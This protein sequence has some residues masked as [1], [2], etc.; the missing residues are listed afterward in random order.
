MTARL[1]HADDY[2]LIIVLTWTMCNIP[3]AR[4]FKSRTR[5]ITARDE[6]RRAGVSYQSHTVALDS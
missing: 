1:E 5:F 6:L 2:P 3:H 4:V